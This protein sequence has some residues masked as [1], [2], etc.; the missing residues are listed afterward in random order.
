VNIKLKQI[1]FLER[2]G[3]YFGSKVG[4]GVNNLEMEENRQQNNNR[5]TNK[6]TTTLVHA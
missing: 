5:T 4:S 3:A 2:G 1:N 6:T